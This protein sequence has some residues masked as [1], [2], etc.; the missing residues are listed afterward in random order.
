MKDAHTELQE[1]IVGLEKDW[2]LTSGTG[3]RLINAFVIQVGKEGWKAS[4][5]I[6]IDDAGNNPVY[7]DFAEY[8]PSIKQIK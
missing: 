3:K 4:H 6:D 5:A 2:P 1:W 8:Q 7:E